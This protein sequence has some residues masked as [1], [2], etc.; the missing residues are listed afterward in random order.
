MN[1][2]ATVASWCAAHV[3]RV[4]IGWV[5]AIVIVGALGAS[6]GG[7]FQDTL[8]VPGTQSDRAQ[9]FVES[10]IGMW[11]GVTARLVFHGPPGVM[12]SASA[13]NA[14]PL[15]IDTVRRTKDVLD[16]DD[17]NEPG[18]MSA[19]GSTIFVDVTFVPGPPPGVDA[20]ERLTHS[21][22]G[23]RQFGIRA[24]VGGVLPEVANDPS[25]GP[26]EY[27]GLLVAIVVLYFVFGS[28]RA[29]ALP[30]VVAIAGVSV[31][32]GI[33]WIIAGATPVSSFA[34][35]LAGMVGLGVGIDYALLI[36]TRYRSE[37]HRGNSNNSAIVTALTSAGRASVIAGATVSISILGLVVV[38]VPFITN[39][40][41]ATVLCVAGVVA[42]AIT[43]LPALVVR[44]D[45]RITSAR[46]VRRAPT[47]WDNMVRT[48]VARPVRF[49]VAAFVV[50]A[51][52]G[53]PAFALRVGFT[54]ASS[55]SH[56]STERVAYDTL[57]A[58]Y[59]AGANASLLVAI[60][61]SNAS[62][63]RRDEIAKLVRSAISQSG[64]ANFVGRPLF[65]QQ[66]EQAVVRFDL[67]AAPSSIDAQRSIDALRKTVVPDALRGTGS[68]GWVGGPT[69]TKIDLARRVGSSLP[70][71]ILSVVALSVVV[72]MRSL[73]SVV[74]PIKAAVLNLLSLLAAYGVVVAVFQWGW[75][76]SVI[77]L[78][79]P[80]AIDAF[81]PV[82]MFG[83]LF[84]L[85]MDYEVFLMTRI[86]EAFDGGAD[87]TASVVSGVSDTAQVVT[88]A[89]AIMVAIFSGFIFAHDPVTKM[90]G[91]GLSVAVLVDAT[92]IRFVV[93]PSTM[94][95]LGNAN[96]WW[97][98]RKD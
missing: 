54:D 90:F 86:R 64:L 82:F 37:R 28:W 16:I 33:V 67:V 49:L 46:S 66:G 9:A 95:I 6:F 1:I 5:L 84:G 26:L 14:L 47:N 77:G 80:V 41:I 83:I 17:P 21:A 38:R 42:A 96:W 63:P 70:V 22:D 43:L 74:V 97:P 78:D 24:D 72:L 91:V 34:P 79:N 40:A 88:S 48:V 12:N 11:S 60:D 13:R 61:M 29:A 35:Q 94:A 18:R 30:I 10:N 75:L 36:V 7:A 44:W 27:L 98:R 92:L 62:P 55:A 19:D 20:I 8:T 15:A 31:G 57:A 65:G 93:L 68:V 73:R 2:L 59:R 81:V 71:L 45:A 76:R 23:L 53:V 51:A 56:S 85:S 87:A 52:I 69:A 32:M 50:V 3:R 25:P 4:V 58:K 39:M 89:A